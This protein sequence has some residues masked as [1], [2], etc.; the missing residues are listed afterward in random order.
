MQAIAV[1]KRIMKMRPEMMM[2]VILRSSASTRAF[3]SSIF[4]SL[5]LLEGVLSCPLLGGLSSL[6]NEGLELLLDPDVRFS[7]RP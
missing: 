6:E 4:L 2:K 1:A 3:L 5:W 7:Y